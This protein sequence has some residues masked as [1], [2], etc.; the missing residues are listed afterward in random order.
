MKPVI[1]PVG[2]LVKEPRMT[3]ASL[4]GCISRL[5]FSSVKWP[6]VARRVEARCTGSGPKPGKPDALDLGYKQRK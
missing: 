6:A 1:L 2:T 3:S 5:D 4:A